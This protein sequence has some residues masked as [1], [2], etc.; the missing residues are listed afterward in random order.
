MYFARKVTPILLAI[1]LAIFMTFINVSSASDTLPVQPYSSIIPIGHE[2]CDMTVDPVRPYLYVSDSTDNVVL[3]VNT[4]TDTI[5]KNIW[6]GSK[7]TD[8]DISSD[9][10]TLYVFVGSENDYDIEVST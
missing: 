2:L 8:M 10:S 9:N 4:E 7:P 6:V 1:A 5:G 3:V